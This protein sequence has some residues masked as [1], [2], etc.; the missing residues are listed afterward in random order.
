L[1]FERIIDLEHVLVN[2]AEAARLAAN[3]TTSNGAP[4]SSQ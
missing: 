3:Q 1:R 2:L 4:P